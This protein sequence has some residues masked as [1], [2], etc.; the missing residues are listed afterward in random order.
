M[1]S[2]ILSFPKHSW[3]AKAPLELVHSDIYGP[4]QTPTLGGYSYFILFVD[5]CT[6]MMWIYFLKQKFEAFSTF[7][8]FKAQ[9]ETY[10]GK[11]NKTLRIDRRGEFIYSPF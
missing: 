5:D 8:Q 10:S 6:R 9:V 1:E 11:K 2:Y 7:L 3:R 4:M